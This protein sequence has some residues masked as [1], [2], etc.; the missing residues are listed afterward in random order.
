[1]TWTADRGTDLFEQ[2]Q[3]WRV[4]WRSKRRPLSPSLLGYTVVLADGTTAEDGSVFVVAT[5]GGEC[6][7]LTHALL[8]SLIRECTTLCG[9]VVIALATPPALT[10]FDHEPI[11]ELEVLIAVGHNRRAG[12]DHATVSLTLTP[13]DLART[14][15]T[16][17]TPKRPEGWPP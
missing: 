12:A 8:R 7:T 3:R 14:R 1:M 6:V 5:E 15:W 17:T 2:A 9:E 4:V 10:G 13:A 11:A 16:I